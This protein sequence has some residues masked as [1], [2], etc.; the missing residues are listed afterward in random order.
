MLSTS[1]F[2][3]VVPFGLSPRLREWGRV[4]ECPTGPGVGG[5]GLPTPEGEPG[6]RGVRTKGEQEG[7]GR[8]EVSLGVRKSEVIRGRG[9]SGKGSQEG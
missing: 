6:G 8:S 7:L 9:W 2:S 3:H 4:R 5:R 1:A